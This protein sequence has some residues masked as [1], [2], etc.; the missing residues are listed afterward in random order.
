M[1]VFTATIVIEDDETMGDYIANNDIEAAFEPVIEQD[2][3]GQPVLSVEICLP[4]G[5]V[6]SW[7]MLETDDKTIDRLT[8]AI[9]SIIGQPD[10]IT[11]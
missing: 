10:T 7:G 4:D 5:S 3:T 6:A 8:D 1:Q 11:L 2:N 9:E